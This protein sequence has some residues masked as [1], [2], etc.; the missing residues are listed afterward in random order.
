MAKLVH[1]SEAASLALHSMVIIARGNGHVNVNTL[2]DE[3][4]S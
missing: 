2:A 1:F 3:M 4:G